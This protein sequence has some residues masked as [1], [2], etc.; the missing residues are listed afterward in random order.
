MQSLK[1]LQQEWLAYKGAQS[2][3]PRIESYREGIGRG[4]HIAAEGIEPHL[5]RLDALEAVA[6]AARELLQEAPWL[7]YRGVV[8]TISPADQ[9]AARDKADVLRSQLRALGDT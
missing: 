9:I 4:L 6:K 5:A 7:F 2:D 8:V 3:V 1:A